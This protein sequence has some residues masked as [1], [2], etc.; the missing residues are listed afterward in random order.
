MRD[1]DTIVDVIVLLIERTLNEYDLELD[2]EEIEGLRGVLDEILI[3]KEE[4]V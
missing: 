2:E 1:N 3:S 4:L